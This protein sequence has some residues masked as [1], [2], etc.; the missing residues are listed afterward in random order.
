MKFLTASSLLISLFTP[1]TLSAEE[2]PWEFSG[3]GGFSFTDGNS[4]TLAYSLQF[5]GSY[6]GDGDRA[7][8]GADYFYSEDGAVK[9]TDSLKIFGQ[10]NYDLGERTYVAGYGSYF[11][12]SVAEID[13]RIDTAV[14]LGYQVIESETTD[15]A[16]EAG[17]GYSW[18]ERGGMQRDF[19]TMRFVEKFEYRF[20]ETTKFWQSLGFTPT[21][22]DF[23]DYILDF[24]LGI[25]TRITDRWSLRTFMKHRVNSTPAAGKGRSDT[26]IMLGAGYDFSGL[27]EPLEAGRRTL[28][29]GS[30]GSAGTNDNWKSVAALGFSMNRGNSDSMSFNLSWNS[31]YR[32]DER[33]FFFEVAQSLKENSGTN[34]EDQTIS[35][36]QY[37]HF[38]SERSYLGATLGFLRDAVAEIDYRITPGIIA[39][40]YVVKNDTTDLAFEAGPAYTF[41]SVGGMTENYISV[42]FAERFSHQ[43][44]ERLSFKQSA[45]FVAEAADFDNHSLLVTAGFDTKL[46]DRL[47]WQ[48]GGK[49]SFENQPA[50]GRESED[51]SLTSSVAMKF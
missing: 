2:S 10:Y 5:L 32:S 12:D 19:A 23:S 18:E 29:P 28:F 13:Y 41:E 37:N 17:P 9:S 40:Y 39:G 6:I 11:R 4:D 44:N 35:R 38:V 21:I 42:V 15:L 25:E 51:I 7:T 46:N 33:E 49:F 22:E 47:S 50:A 24:E 26:A 45:E 16:F 20:N 36:T 34:S 27:P 31:E 14:L 8:V 43:F 3:A 1:L 30:G 48:I